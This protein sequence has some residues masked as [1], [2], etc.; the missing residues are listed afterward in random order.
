MSQ[1]Q[2]QQQ[3]LPNQPPAGYDL[4]GWQYPHPQQ[5]Q[6]QQ[7]GQPAPGDTDSNQQPQQGQGMYSGAYSQVPHGMEG[8]QTQQYQYPP[9]DMNQQ[10]QY[11]QY[12]Y[13]PAPPQ[14]HMDHAQAPH[15]HAAYY[16]PQVSQQQQGAGGDHDGGVQQNEQELA[17]QPKAVH[18]TSGAAHGP[19]PY[20]VAAVAIA[21]S[22]AGVRAEVVL[23]RRTVPPSEAWESKYVQLKEFYEEFGHSSVPQSYKTNRALGKCKFMV[24]NIADYDIGGGR[25]CFRSSPRIPL[26]M[27]LG[28]NFLQML[29]NII[30]ISE[31]MVQGSESR[32]NTGE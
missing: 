12:P 4:H 13:P 23:R 22:A 28:P 29:I 18:P 15:Q 8:Y 19:P 27:L 6:Q 21:G 11:Q 30:L 2:Q 25:H 31:S 5:Q 9:A 10:Q 14:H 26:I 24:V 17:L 32:G 20:N 1:Q 7:G 3:P 16:H